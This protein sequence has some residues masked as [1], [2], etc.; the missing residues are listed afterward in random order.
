[1]P[2]GHVQVLG[3]TVR[4]VALRNDGDISLGGPPE[5]DLGGG[6]A[7]LVGNALDGRVVEEGR[8]ILG[9]LQ[10]EFDEGLRAKG[11]V[12]CHGDA[13]LLGKFDEV[14]LGQVGMMFD[15]QGGR[16]DLGVAEKID[17]ERGTVIADADAFSQPLINQCLHCLPGFLVGGFAR[18]HIVA[19]IKEPRGIF[20]RRVD[21]FEG[22][23]EVHNEEIEIINPPVLQL[24][25][26][27]R[28]HS[29][30][31]VKSTP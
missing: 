2:R 16:N 31:F 4:V 11:R 12:G 5:Q 29:F 18:D 13:L 19:L 6:F 17:N 26:A 8:G 30:S 3:Q 9:L 7:L 25:F 15:L 20:L 24:F 21:I 28:S 27:D 22:D 10:T 14:W 23:W 1:M